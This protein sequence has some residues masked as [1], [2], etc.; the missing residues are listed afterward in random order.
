[1]Y[2]FNAYNIFR[3]CIRPNRVA[4][5]PG[6]AQP[7]ESPTQQLINQ[8]S[9]SLGV[10][11]RTPNIQAV[12]MINTNADHEHSDLASL[13]AYIQQGKGSVID[14]VNDLFC[15]GLYVQ[16]PRMSEIVCA[17]KGFYR[18]CLHMESIEDYVQRLKPDACFRIA[19]H[20][21]RQQH[22]DVGKQLL[23]KLSNNDH[24]FYA[25][26][27]L[28]QHLIKEYLQLPEQAHLESALYS[29]DPQLYE[30]KQL[31]NEALSNTTGPIDR[32]NR[33]NSLIQNT[34]MYNVQHNRDRALK[35][36][37]LLRFFRVTKERVSAPSHNRFNT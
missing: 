15:P 14:A 13:L 10:A 20:L 16:D 25:Q 28:I 21:L 37:L 2:T 17:R 30:I 22:I 34:C 1:M 19:L 7:L 4:N 11:L 23:L 5:E 29:K 32:K 3:H 24:H 33:I 12:S 9:N 31:I 27:F 6:L 18:L 8:L 36:Y 26:Q 35:V